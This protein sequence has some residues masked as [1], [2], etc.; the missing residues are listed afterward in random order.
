MTIENQIEQTFLAKSFSS[1]QRSREELK[2]FIKILRISKPSFHSLKLR[3]I[4]TFLKYDYFLRE[5][6][7]ATP[8]NF[9]GAVFRFDQTFHRRTTRE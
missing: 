5:D 4:I 9:L 8:F 6:R 3:K 1:A 7:V 2:L